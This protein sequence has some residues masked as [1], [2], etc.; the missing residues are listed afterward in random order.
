MN[1]TLNGSYFEFKVN[2]HFGSIRKLLTDYQSTF[3]ADHISSSVIFHQNGIRMVWT[4]HSRK[5]I[6][7]LKI[8]LN[9]FLYVKSYSS[10]VGQIYGKDNFLENP[11]T[12]FLKEISMPKNAL[13][14]KTTQIHKVLP[15]A[16]TAL[17]TLVDPSPKFQFSY[18]LKTEKGFNTE[19]IKVIWYSLVVQYK[20]LHD[21]RKKIQFYVFHKTNILNINISKK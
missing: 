2:L 8:N 15:F 12:I 19:H 14:Q 11:T 18:F 4:C 5:H 21:I 10:D 16:Y 17:C 20:I 9:I 3:W 7:A 6:Q 1:K 13:F